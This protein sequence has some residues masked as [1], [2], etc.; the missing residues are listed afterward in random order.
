M[1]LN[2]LKFVSVQGVQKIYYDH[3]LL[4]TSVTS[5]LAFPFHA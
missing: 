2:I 5:V 4:S 3:F 1:F